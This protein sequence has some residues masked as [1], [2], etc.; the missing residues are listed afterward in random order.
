VNYINI[1]TTLP[2]TGLS[3]NLLIS[4]LY[5]SPLYIKTVSRPFKRARR[6]RTLDLYPRIASS[7]SASTSSS[8]SP[9]SASTPT[10]ANGNNLSKETKVGDRKRRRRWIEE[11]KI[12]SILVVIGDV[13]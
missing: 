1:K 2:L 7:R 4:P 6:L 10:S 13:R 11:E 3:S 12:T 5:L 9:L 8:A